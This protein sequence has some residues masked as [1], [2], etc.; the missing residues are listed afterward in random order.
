MTYWIILNFLVEKRFKKYILIS[1]DLCVAFDRGDPTWSEPQPR[2]S[3]LNSDWSRRDAARNTVDRWSG[4]HGGGGLFRRLSKR[5][6]AASGEVRYWGV[7]YKPHSWR[8]PTCAN[9]PGQG[10]AGISKDDLLSLSLSVSLLPSFSPFVLP[11]SSHSSGR[12]D[13]APK[14]IPGEMEPA[15]KSGGARGGG[16]GWRE[17]TSTAGEAAMLYRSH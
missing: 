3:L 17:Q 4:I 7:S 14:T 11:P 2:A 12:H 5:L 10:V 13:T 6:D 15:Q 16:R 9:R 1:R 8:H